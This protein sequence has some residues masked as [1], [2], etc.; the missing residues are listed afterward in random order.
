MGEEVP[1][2]LVGP[3]EIL[4]MLG[5]GRSRFRQIIVHPNFPRPFQTL[6]AGSVWLR[7]D[8]EAY[9]AKYRQPRPPADEDELG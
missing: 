6:M 7:S 8:V 1:G 9:I 4:A 3:G 5:V 2:P